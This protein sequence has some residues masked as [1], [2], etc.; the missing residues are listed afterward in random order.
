[1]SSSFPNKDW[2]QGE[3]MSHE[4]LGGVFSLIVFAQSQLNVDSFSYPCV[5][6]LN[7]CRKI[8]PTTIFD[9]L[10]MNGIDK[11]YITWY[12][13][14]DPFEDDDAIVKPHVTSSNP[15]TE[16]V[17][18]MLHLGDDTFM[19]VKSED[20]DPSTNDVSFDDVNGQEQPNLENEDMSTLKRLAIGHDFNVVSYKSYRANGYVFCTKESE[21]SM[22][23]QDSGVT[24]KAVTS[25]VSS[26]KDL[27]PKEEETTYYGFVK[28]ILE[29]NYYDFMQRVFYCDWVKVEDKVNGCITET[30]MMIS[31]DENAQ[32]I[33]KNGANFSSK[34]GLAVKTYYSIF[35]EFWKHVS[36][37]SKNIVWKT[38]KDEFNVPG[39]MKA[40]VLKRA[41]KLWVENESTL[42]KKYYDKYNTDEERKKI[43]PK[44]VRIEDWDKFVDLQ[45]KPIV[46]AHRKRGKNKRKAM[47]IP[48]TTGRRGTGRTTEN[49]KVLVSESVIAGDFDASMFKVTVDDVNFEVDNNTSFTDPA[50]DYLYNVKIGST[51]SWPKAFTHFIK[52]WCTGYSIVLFFFSS[53]AI[54][55]SW[56]DCGFLVYGNGYYLVL[57][58]MQPLG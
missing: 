54:Y 47:K 18:R 14:E 46:I 33:G 49:M 29:L 50:F 31:F 42:Q 17:P 15:V 5:K 52:W 41:N 39:H 26:K 9:D 58:V 45:W 21:S 28:E 27:N 1:M 53:V 4:F 10:I 37:D 2:M 11:S 20:I 38:I 7:K 30:R 24:M 56:F 19:C 25:L 57:V 16:D 34:V 8:T 35:H 22:T 44:G 43:V 48:H 12:L 55:V 6:C 36:D 40:K 51:I 13:H 32:P 3:K 23:I